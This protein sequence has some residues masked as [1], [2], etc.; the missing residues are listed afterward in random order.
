[1]NP[2]ERAGDDQA[3]TVESR[4]KGGMLA[5]RSLTVVLLARSGRKSTRVVSMT[6][7]WEL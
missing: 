1:M 3:A 2:G 6:E 4:L 7:S 5:G